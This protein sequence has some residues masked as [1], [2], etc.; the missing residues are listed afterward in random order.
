MT[1]QITTPTLVGRDTDLSVRDITWEY[2]HKSDA[3]Y[4]VTDWGTDYSFPRKIVGGVECKGWHKDIDGRCYLTD[5]GERIPE[6][7]IDMIKQ[8]V[9]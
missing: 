1:K 3:L 2:D 8:E 6:D 7:V 4:V 9:D 5:N